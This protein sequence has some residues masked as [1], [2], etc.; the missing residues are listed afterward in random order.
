MD[1]G[2]ETGIIGDL[3]GLGIKLKRGQRGRGSRVTRRRNKKERKALEQK[4]FELS[5]YLNSTIFNTIPSG[6]T[7]EEEGYVKIDI[8]Y[9]KKEI[10][11]TVVK[12]EREVS[13]QYEVES[14]VRMVVQRVKHGDT[15]QNDLMYE[16]KWVGFENT[17]LEPVE[18]LDNNMAVDSFWQSQRGQGEDY[19][20]HFVDC[21]SE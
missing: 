1:Q 15:F 4:C 14:I 16:V 9:L 7:E 10:K 11:K 12:V 21:S 18:E 5:N 2:K 6:L 19:R 20:V 13:M 8:N 17:T 3:A